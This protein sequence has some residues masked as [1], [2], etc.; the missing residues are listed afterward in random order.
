M[1]SAL[2]CHAAIGTFKPLGEPHEHREFYG[3]TILVTQKDAADFKAK[4]LD[5]VPTCDWK[6][7]WG[8]S[9]GSIVY[10]S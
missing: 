8:P 1:S 2:A 5:N 10:R 9:N 4:Y 3:P 6:D 7:F